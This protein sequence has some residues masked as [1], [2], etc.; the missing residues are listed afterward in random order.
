M[1]RRKKQKHYIVGSSLPYAEVSRNI[2]SNLD[3]ET[4]SEENVSGMR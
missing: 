4:N 3:V 2:L 1:G